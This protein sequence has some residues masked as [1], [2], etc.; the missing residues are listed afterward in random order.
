MTI[1]D[2]TNINTS[3]SV[4]KHMHECE[5]TAHN[6]WDSLTSDISALAEDLD[7]SSAILK[8]IDHLKRHNVTQATIGE[9]SKVTSTVLP[10]ALELGKNKNAV[11]KLNIAYEGLIGNIYDR[12]KR[13]VVAIG[14]GLY[15]LVDPMDAK[16][17][18]IKELHTELKGEKLNEGPITN[19]VITAYSKEIRNNVTKLINAAGKHVKELGG[20]AVKG[21]LSGRVTKY[22][23]LARLDS[24]TD[25]FDHDQVEKSIKDLGYTTTDILNG[26][27]ELS[28]L[29]STIR[30]VIAEIETV[31]NK[32]ENVI[33]DMNQF[34]INA[35]KLA[36]PENPKPVVEQTAEAKAIID[37]V[38][39]LNTLGGSLSRYGVAFAN[40]NLKMLKVCKKYKVVVD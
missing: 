24:S 23:A 11:T 7:N 32:A 6:E 27:N 14:R 16:L 37:V 21:K 3:D 15:A 39:Y 36:N 18:Y 20:E 25:L 8:T 30:E 4:T 34:S 9:L 31:A 38:D 10:F 1:V 19:T 22:G 28:S 35:A 40:D 17:L 5:I 13:I 33:G 29:R 12:I 2:L 26:Y